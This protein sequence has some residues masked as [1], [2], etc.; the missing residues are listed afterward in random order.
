MLNLLKHS[1]SSGESP[2][3]KK[4]KTDEDDGESSSHS[5]DQSKEVCAVKSLEP[6]APEWGKELL[7]ALHTDM[8]QICS[9]LDSIALNSETSKKE[10]K[11]INK[12]LNLIEIENY[13]LKVENSDLKNKVVD[14]EYRQR[15]C[16]LLFDGIP[17]ATPNQEGKKVE[18]DLDCFS[19]VLTVLKGIPDLSPS[20]SFERCHRLGSPMAKYNR[21]VICC[22]S[23]YQ[24]VSCI[25]ANKK[26]LPKEVFVNED[27]PEEWEEARKVLRPAFKLL[28]KDKN[29]K[30]SWSKDKLIVNGKAYTVDNV[31]DLN[32]ELELLNTCEKRVGNNIIFQGIHSAFSNFHPAPFKLNGIKYNCAEQYIQGQKA[33]IFNDDVTHCKI[34]STDNPY[35]MKKLGNRIKNYDFNTWRSKSNEI[36]YDAMRAKFLQNN[37]LK[38]MLLCTGGISICESTSDRYWGT[39]FNLNHTSST[40]VNAWRGKGKICEFYE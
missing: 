20:V 31:A 32:S 5:V 40:N 26:L 13:K 28:R 36:V 18:S 33:V 34:M 12:K 37:A 7:K 3:K 4:S 39:G 15:R 22:F 2:E 21:T 16:N 25:L 14:L 27:I 10:I 17:D 6:S 19:K 24:D 29:K 38:Q 8:Q 23:R 9:K 1:I 35:R 30:V 11:S